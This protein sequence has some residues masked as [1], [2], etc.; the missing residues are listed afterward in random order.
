M[1]AQ[2]GL[3]FSGIAAIQ[4]PD[5][6]ALGFVLTKLSADNYDYDWLAGGGGG[7]TVDPGTV[8]DTI[9]RWVGATPAW[10]APTWETTASRML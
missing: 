6:G 10:E 7:P 4:I 5:D 1:T 2:S 9:L 3:G 8:D